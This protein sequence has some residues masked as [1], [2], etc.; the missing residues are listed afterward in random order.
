MS[1]YIGNGREEVTILELA[2]RIKART[3]SASEIKIVPYEEA[4]EQGF[5][6]MFRRIP[7][8]T[9]LQALTGYA[10]KVRLDEILQRVI[11]YFTSDRALV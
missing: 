8:I 10:P 7:D 2:E 3:G 1:G 6:D 11:A 4:Y 5:E 9:K